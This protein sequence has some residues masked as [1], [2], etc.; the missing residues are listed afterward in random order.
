MR[1]AR[2]G[3]TIAP[4]RGWR[5][6]LRRADIVRGYRRAQ[7]CPLALLWRRRRTPPESA[8][9]VVHR[10]ASAMASAPLKLDLRVG[11]TVG[12]ERARPF[13]QS[14]TMGRS[15]VPA[16]GATI[17]PVQTLFRTKSATQFAARRVRAGSAATPVSPGA[18]T[19]GRE[20]S[21]TPRLALGWRRLAPATAVPARGVTISA[22]RPV[23]CGV[24]AS[25]PPL[26]VHRT[27]RSAFASATSDAQ[28]A[29]RAPRRAPAV[30]RRAELVWR[31][32]PG[33]EIGAQ[34]FAQATT[35]MVGL[36]ATMKSADAPVSPAMARQAHPAPAGLAATAPDGATVDRIAREVIGRVEK[37]IRIE[38][39]RR[40]V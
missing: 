20:P 1:L 34:T 9:I 21:F 17:E 2:A 28:A 16:T 12:R 10:H 13:P 11:V 3:T 24:R 5:P 7:W 29:T 32:A 31:E 15:T 27:A 26:L 22:A 25:A 36:A 6:C 4:R 19:T 14:M 38:R 37:H 35:T 8:S 30:Q 39:E 18:A 40:G 23:L 33:G